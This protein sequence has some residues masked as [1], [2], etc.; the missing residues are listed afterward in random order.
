MSDSKL[1][2]VLGGIALGIAGTLTFG[3]IAKKK[4]EKTTCG[5]SRVY[6]DGGNNNIVF[7][8]DSD[9]VGGNNNIVFGSSSDYMMEIL[10]VFGMV[11]VWR[12][13]N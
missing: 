4:K 6:K 12:S 1:L 8:G 2:P 7:G 11:C 10:A 13:I 5:C 9:Q 3:R